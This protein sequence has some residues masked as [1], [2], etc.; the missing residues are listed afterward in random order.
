MRDDGPGALDGERRGRREASGLS[1]FPVPRPLPFKGG[2][3][4]SVLPLSGASYRSETD[5][6]SEPEVSQY[7]HHFLDTVPFEGTFRFDY[8]TFLGDSEFEYCLF[9]YEARGG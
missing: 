5:T 6:T 3:N 9:W 1:R 8:E 7:R 4:P 2:A